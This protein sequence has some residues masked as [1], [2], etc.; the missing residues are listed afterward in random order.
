M[1]S[2]L[3]YRAKLI[4][5][6]LFVCTLAIISCSK[7]KI[8]P[9]ATADERIALALKMFEKKHYLDAKTHFRV[10]TLSNSG[11]N[12]A[13]KAQYY[14]GECHYYLKEYILAASEYERLIKVYPNSEYVD[15]SKYKLG[16]C[17]FN[18]SPK[19]SLDQEYT[20]KA[21]KEL[22]EFLE[23]FHSSQLEPQVSEKLYQVREKLAH[24]IYAAAEQYRRLGFYDSAIIYYQKVLESYFDSSYGPKS[25]FWVGECYKKL[26]KNAEAIEAFSSFIDKY[27]RHDLASKAKNRVIELKEASVIDVK[28]AKKTAEAEAS[29]QP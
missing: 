9:N 20:L 26:G 15:D 11:S 24:K 6:W 8:R 18:L 1:Q 2:K 25:Q 23:D 19:Y 21:L 7:N 16:L 17:Y 14:L 13:D 28:S 22:Q 5:L 4:L 12:F 3:S 10:I 27:P 29:R